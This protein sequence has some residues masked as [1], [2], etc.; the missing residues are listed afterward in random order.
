[1]ATSFEHRLPS[2]HSAEDIWRAI[3]TP[4]TGRLAMTVHPWL[5]VDYL[6]LS[7]DMQ[8]EA[9]TLMSYRRSMAL[10]SRVNRVPKLFRDKLPK[11]ITF[12]VEEHDP[13]GRVRLDVLESR[14][15]EGTVR[16]SVEEVDNSGLLVVEGEFSVAGIGSMAEGPGIKHAIHEPALRLLEHLPEIIQSSRGRTL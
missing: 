7:E 2:E 10:V 6:F 9:G 5:E 13:D 1:M 12:R 11:D 14:L 8:I 15:A 3:N 16:H 4:L